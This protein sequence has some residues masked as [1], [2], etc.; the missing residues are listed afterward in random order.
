MIFN[1]DISQHC[2]DQCPPAAAELVVGPVYRGVRVLPVT[3][4][5][6]KSDA[7]LRRNGKDPADCLNWGLS[8][9]RT[10]QAV[11]H[12]R[13]TYRALRRWHIAKGELTGSEG[14]I[15]AT[16]TNSQPQHHTLWKAAGINYLPLFAVVMNPSIA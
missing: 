16:P 2:S 11:V 9:W 8:V 4:E 5:D 1:P 12:A 7:E 6:F 3:E 13:N 14:M 10:E 15:M